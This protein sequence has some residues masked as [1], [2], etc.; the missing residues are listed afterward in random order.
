MKKEVGMLIE[1]TEQHIRSKDIIKQEVN[2]INKKEEK[3]VVEYKDRKR[4]FLIMPFIDDDILL[5]NHTAIVTLNTDKN[6]QWLLSKWNKV[7]SYD[8][9]YVYFINPNLPTDNKWIICPYIHNKVS[10][11]ETFELGLRS[12]F[13]SVPAY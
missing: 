9:L 1:W 4:E 2:Y 10:D 5:E 11:K 8:D 7:A 3:L 12:L 6:F 13:E